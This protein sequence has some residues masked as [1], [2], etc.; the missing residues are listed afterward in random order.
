[1]MWHT[2]AAIGASAIWLLL[3]PLSPGDSINM[4]VVMAFC[5]VGA[6]VP[7]LDAGESKIKHIMVA[8]TKPLVPVAIAINRNFGH[9]G[10]LHSARGWVGWTALIL[11]LGLILGWAAIIAL[12]LGYASHLA[13]D[14]CTR[15]GIPL[16]YPRAGRHFLLPPRL[17]II[18]GSDVEEVFFAVFAC[19]SLV[20]LL[21][22]TSV[23]F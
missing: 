8:G 5:V 22:S 15:T 16:L 13:A 3:P 14:A 7:D 18:T 10:F 12:S 4:G 17:R 20:L 6:L 1:M 23:G 11:P 9:R 2:H 19:L 21:S